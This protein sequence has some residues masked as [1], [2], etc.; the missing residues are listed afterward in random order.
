MPH[1]ET[2]RQVADSLS[3]SVRDCVG[4][5]RVTSLKENG[6]QRKSNCRWI[7]VFSLEAE[8][9]C[10]GSCP[11]GTPKNRV[12]RPPGLRST[13]SD[14]LGQQGLH[15]SLASLPFDEHK[16]RH[17]EWRIWGH[18]YLW[19]RNC[20]DGWVSNQLPQGPVLKAPSPLM[21]SGNKKVS[22]RQH[23]S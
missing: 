13:R 14:P 8:D 2:D 20:C 9:E 11:R 7:Q 21:T 12:G 19:S 10:R 3:R 5:M 15:E 1:W 6:T 18:G 4:K 23:L 16:A 22:E 17:S